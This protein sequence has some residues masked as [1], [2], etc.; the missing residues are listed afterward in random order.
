[1]LSILQNIV[2]N[3]ETIKVGNL[4]LSFS[5]TLVSFLF[6][7]FL[8]N[9]ILISTLEGKQ[10]ITLN[11]NVLNLLQIILDQEANI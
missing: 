2:T 8:L 7:K 4:D 5:E 11:K 10:D 6:D 3:K 1:M 9:F